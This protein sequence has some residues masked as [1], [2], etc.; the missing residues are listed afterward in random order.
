[1]SVPAATEVSPKAHTPDPA[2]RAPRSLR[3][4]YLYSRRSDG[5]HPTSPDGATLLANAHAGGI[6]AALQQ[7]QQRRRQ[8]GAAGPPMPPPLPPP[9]A[10]PLGHQAVYDRVP[11]PFPSAAP[12]SH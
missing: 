5:V 12:L 9:P 8:G 1:M 6:L 11:L 3:G 10:E 4:P 7:Q 2:P